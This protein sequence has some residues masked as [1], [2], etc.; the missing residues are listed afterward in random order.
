MTS[1]RARAGAGAEWFKGGWQIFRENALVWVVI[2]VVLV[3]IALASNLIPLVGGVVL[4]VMLPVLLGGI[5]RLAAG[6]VPLEV[7]RLFIVFQDPPRRSRLMML[8]LIMFAVS[9]AISL[10]LGIPVLGPLLDLADPEAV[11]DLELMIDEM[12][13]PSHLVLLLVLLVVQLVVSFGCIFAVGLVTFRDAAPVPA[14]V[15]GVKTAFNNLLPLVV[16][17]AIYSALGV[18]AAFTLGVGFLVLLPVTL[19]GGYCAYRDLYGSSLAA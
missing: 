7:S 2:A 15:D 5:F 1:D 12:L 6:D 10:T 11:P 13:Q 18:L 4:M 14:F 9:V 19:L 16:F 3:A 17:G 8:G